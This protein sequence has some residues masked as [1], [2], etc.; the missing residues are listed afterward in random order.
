MISAT[1]FEA[2]GLSPFAA[3][4]RDHALIPAPCEYRRIVNL[5][6]YNTPEREEFRKGP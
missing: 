6:F 4:I 1:Y 3:E 5:T 2:P